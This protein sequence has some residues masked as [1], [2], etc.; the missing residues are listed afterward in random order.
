MD[1]FSR[2]EYEKFLLQN[3]FSAVLFE[4]KIISEEKRKQFFNFISGGVNT[5]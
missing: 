4:Q 2:T 1:K 5:F 3:N